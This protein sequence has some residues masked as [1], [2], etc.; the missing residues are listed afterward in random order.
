MAITGDVGLKKA[1]EQSGKNV[2]LVDHSKIRLK[3][4]N[5]GVVGGSRA[6]NGFKIYFFGNPNTIDGFQNITEIISDY[7]INF[8]PTEDNMLFD[9]GGVKFFEKP[10]F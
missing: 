1:L 4:Y 6:V 10:Q 8:I 5:H 7:E 2:F 3:G 9:Y